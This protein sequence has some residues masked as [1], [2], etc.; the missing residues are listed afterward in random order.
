MWLLIPIIATIALVVALWVLSIIGADPTRKT[1]EQLYASFNA[2]LRHQKLA[3][4]VDLLKWTKSV[5]RLKLLRNE[6]ERRGY[7][8]DK[9][10]LEEANAKW[11]QRPMD[12]SR[13][14]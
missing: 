11:E 10:M 4:Q 2:Q 13:C 7:S 1:D 8:L 9:L 12:F 6:L 5:E 14:R 3:L